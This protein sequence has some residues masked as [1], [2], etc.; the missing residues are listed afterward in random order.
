MNTI[1]PTQNRRLQ[2]G[3]RQAIDLRRGA[4]VDLV[5]F[6]EAIGQAEVDALI[7]EG[8]L[9]T[10]QPRQDDRRFPRTQRAVRVGLDQ[11]ARP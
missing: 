3:R 6:I 7:A 1:Y 11:V 10:R 5:Q 9:S 4:E 8:V 2:L